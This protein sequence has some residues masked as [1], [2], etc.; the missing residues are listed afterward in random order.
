LCGFIR[1]EVM[2]HHQPAAS[3]LLHRFSAGFVS[4]DSPVRAHVDLVINDVTFWVNDLHHSTAQH[5][6]LDG[7]C[8]TT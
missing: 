6:M 8:S 5:S 2:S 3:Y 1:W 7:L 4:S